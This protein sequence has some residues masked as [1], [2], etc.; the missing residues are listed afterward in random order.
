[1]PEEIAIGGFGGQGVLFI[2]RLLAEAAFGEGHEVAF[3]PSYGAEKRGGTVWC[4]ITISEEKVGSLFILR[5]T[6]AIAMNPASLEK[7]ENAVKPD[8]LL[9]INKSLVPAGVKR[10]DIDVLSIPAIELAAELGDNSA[11]NL[12]VLGAL[13]C[14]RPVVSVSSIRG[15]LDSMSRERLDSNMRSLDYGYQWA[16]ENARPARKV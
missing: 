13:I 9:V 5:P 2:G 8:G 11:A 1:V 12:I 7:F 16:K 15:I 3:M 10:E 6:I 4:H 14:S